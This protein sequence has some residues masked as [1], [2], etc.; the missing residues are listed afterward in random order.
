MQAPTERKALRAE[1]LVRRWE[2]L[3]AD[4]SQATRT[5]RRLER[6]TDVRPEEANCLA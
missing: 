4:R 2:R 3:V 5:K 1:E 6:T